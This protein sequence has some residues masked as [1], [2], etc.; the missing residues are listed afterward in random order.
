M[1]KGIVYA[2]RSG[3]ILQRVSVPTRR[4]LSHQARD[5]AA[6][7]EYDVDAIEGLFSMYYVDPQTAMLTER[8]TIAP[9]V[10]TSIGEATLTSL[11]D[12]C[13]I[14]GQ[15]QAFEVSGGAATIQFDE[16]GQY[17]LQITAE[18]THIARELTVTIP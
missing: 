6:V 14:S 16:P 11:P 18:P 10:S 3:Q 7:I 1:I 5:G 15:G 17:I 12:P 8:D 2:E 4:V 9:G 13:T